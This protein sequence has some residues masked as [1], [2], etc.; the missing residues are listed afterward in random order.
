[1]E[2]K[3]Q[4]LFLWYVVDFNFLSILFVEVIKTLGLL[5]KACFIFPM[6]N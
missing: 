2:K 5:A 3:N 4:N 1:M 6:G